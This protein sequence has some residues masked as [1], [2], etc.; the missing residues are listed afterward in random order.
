MV[1]FCLHRKLKKEQ[2]VTVFTVSAVFLMPR[3]LSF[4]LQ[5]MSVLEK[6]PVSSCTVTT[7]CDSEAHTARQ[8]ITSQIRVSD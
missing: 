5:A 8:H 1:S 2:Y 6:E 7:Q 3:K 4:L